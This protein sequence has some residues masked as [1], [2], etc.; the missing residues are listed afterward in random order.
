MSY[1]SFGL[2]FALLLAAPWAI[3]DEGG[4]VILNDLTEDCTLFEALNGSED[5]PAYCKQASGFRSTKFEKQQ[6]A[7]PRP[8]VLQRVTFEFDSARLTFD[9]LTDL[10]RVAKTMKDPVSERHVYHL[11]GYTDASGNAGHNVWL[12][13]RRAYSVRQHLIEL[14]VPS[15]RLSV[16][17]FGSQGLLYPDRPEDPDNRRVEV[18]QPNG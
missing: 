11:A 17:G 10:S 16:E 9:A 7:G 15:A 4:R 5:V 1:P 14:G 13:K 6:P 12:S 3:A 8:T 18:M 2:A